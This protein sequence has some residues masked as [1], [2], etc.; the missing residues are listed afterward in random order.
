M[1]TICEIN[2]CNGCMACANVCPKNCIEVIDEIKSFNP[3]VNED[4]CINCKLCYKV[5]PNQS[6]VIRIKPIE[7]KQG[8]ATSEIRKYSTSGGAAS[9]IMKSFIQSG[10]YVASCLLKDGQFV[11]EITKDTEV[12]KR[13]AGSKYVKSNPTGIYKKVQNRLK[14]DKVLFIGLPCQVAALKNYI[15]NQENLYTIDLICHGTPSVKLLEQY[16]N[17]RGYNL[18]E[19]K[20]IQFRTKVDMGLC[21]D[22]KK[23]NLSRVMDHYLCSFLESIDYTENCYS[24]QFASLERVSDL[25]LGDSWGTEYK[26]QEKNGISLLLAQTEHGRELISISGMEFKDVD[27]NNA[28]DNNHQLKHP[29]MLSTKRDIFF[30]MIDSGKSFKLATFRVLPKMIIKQQIKRVLISLHLVKV[31]GYRTTLVLKGD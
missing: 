4:L 29:S 9:A 28:I 14:T 18:N 12:A 31:G 22:E 1:K 23:I 26:E 24:C 5:C 13:F 27:L 17:E 30:R 20:D 2:K 19:I 7:W 21:V 6:Q 15:K 10:G 8:W 11:F 16:L 25:T 3:V